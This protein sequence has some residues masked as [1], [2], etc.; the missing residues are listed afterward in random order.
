MD[1]MNLRSEQK[2]KANTQF[3]VIDTK[4]LLV[5]SFD[6][7]T[8]LR[9]AQAALGDDDEINDFKQMLENFRTSTTK[10]SKAAEVQAEHV[11]QTLALRYAYAD[12]EVANWSK[13]E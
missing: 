11:R 7:R 3:L 5:S 12:M 6:G 4:S 1:H 13:T 2:E 9:V 8:P 10:E